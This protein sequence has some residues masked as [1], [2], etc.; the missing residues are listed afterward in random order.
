VVFGFRVDKGNRIPIILLTL[1]YEVDPTLAFAPERLLE[2]AE[3]LIRDSVSDALDGSLV[4][5]G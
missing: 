5:F 4:G 3:Q 1:Q 2:A